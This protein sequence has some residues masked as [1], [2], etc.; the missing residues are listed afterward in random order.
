L[1]DNLPDYTVKFYNKEKVFEEKNFKIDLKE[2][3]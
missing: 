3:I 2:V 1:L